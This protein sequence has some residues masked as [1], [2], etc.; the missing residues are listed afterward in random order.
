MR[1]ARRTHSQLM[2][3]NAWHHRSDS[4]SSIVVLVGLIASQFGYGFADAIAAGIVA[5]MVAR[6]R[7]SADCLQHY[8]A[9]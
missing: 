1:I 6:H 7:L 3:A 4:I 2:K 5:I 9:G 8:G